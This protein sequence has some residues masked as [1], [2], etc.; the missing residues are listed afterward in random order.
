MVEY[1][2]GKS[3][4]LRWEWNRDMKEEII[5]SVEEEYSILGMESS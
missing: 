2:Y 4:L 3:L 5:L 1:V